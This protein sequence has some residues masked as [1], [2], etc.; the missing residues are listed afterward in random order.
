MKKTILKMIFIIL[1]LII[2]TYIVY[3]QSIPDNL[4]IFEGE[5]I[6]FKTILGLKAD[7]SENLESIETSANTQTNTINNC[8]RTTAKISLFN[9]IFLKD[10]SIDVLPKT[11][12][13]PIRKC[14]RN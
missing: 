7:I 11:T 9:N 2:Y 5:S 8:G 4:V 3:I 12:V 1:L 13:I 10:V 14:C 6:S